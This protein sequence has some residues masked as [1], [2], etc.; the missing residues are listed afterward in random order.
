[1]QVRTYH[2]SPSRCFAIQ[3]L[4]GVL[5]LQV[6]EATVHNGFS[7]QDDGSSDEGKPGKEL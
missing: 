6:K 1:M 7:R 2:L 3:R 5:K 4:T